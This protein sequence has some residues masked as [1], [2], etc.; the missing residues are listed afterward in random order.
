AASAGAPVGSGSLSWSA[1]LVDSAGVAQTGK[2]LTAA[3]TALGDRAPRFGSVRNTGTAALT[4]Q[5]YTAS[6]SGLLPSPVRVDACVGAAWNTAANTCAGTVTT[7]VLSSAGT[8]SP[9]T[10]LAVGGQLGIR[11][12]LTGGLSGNTNATIGVSVANNAHIRTAT[13]TNS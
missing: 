2:P 11:V 10:A 7:L 8:A 9:A 3:W 6:V 4:G 12:S 5:T 13:T 1:V